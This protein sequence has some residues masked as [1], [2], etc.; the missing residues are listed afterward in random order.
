MWKPEHRR[1]ANRHGLRY[2]SDLSDSEWALIEPSIPPAKRGGRR[3]EVNVRE[4]LNAIF[5]VLSTGCQW[6]ALPKDRLPVAGVAE[7]PATEKHRALLLYAVGLGR[8][9]GAHPSR[10]LCRD[11]RARRA[12]GEPDGRDHRQPECQSQSK[13]GSALDP[14]GFDAGKKVIGRKRHILVDTLG[15]LLNVVVH[16]ANVQDR[17]GARLVLDRRTRC[18]FPFIER[19]FADAGYQG[20]RVARTAASTGHWVVEIVKRNEM[21]KF[22]VLPKRW[23]VERT[24]AWISRN[25]RLARDFERYARTVAAFVRLAM[26]RI[27]LRRLTRPSHST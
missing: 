25:R 27:M 23:I 4:V 15:L 17:D 18:L 21:H 3:R 12:R 13:R 6:Q 8:H 19:I 14:Q 5:Y 10:A 20:P 7:G 16:P 9:P 2:P 11:P 1:A 24:L 26:I 22:V